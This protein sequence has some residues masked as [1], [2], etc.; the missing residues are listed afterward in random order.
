MDGVCL[1][2]K[3]ADRLDLSKDGNDVSQVVHTSI[4][5]IT[6]VIGKVWLMI[7]YHRESISSSFPF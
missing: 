2:G 7:C 6:T 1:G 5:E 4:T 3:C